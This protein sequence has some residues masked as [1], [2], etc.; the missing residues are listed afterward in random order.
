MWYLIEVVP[1][2]LSRMWR[3][4]GTEIVSVWKIFN[5]FFLRDRFHQ[6]V[7]WETRVGHRTCCVE[8]GKKMIS[9]VLIFFQCFDFWRCYVR[10]SLIC[11]GRF[12]ILLQTMIFFALELGRSH[13]FLF[14][15]QIGGELKGA[16]LQKEKPDLLIF[17]INVHILFFYANIYPSNFDHTSK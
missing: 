10:N 14:G 7:L 13:L 1:P 16:I 2:D 15:V 8:E 11:C 6:L 5:N 3:M 12:S 9:N 17:A 4:W